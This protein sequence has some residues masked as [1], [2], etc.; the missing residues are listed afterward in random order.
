MPS[1][2]DVTNRMSK[3]KEARKNALINRSKLPSGDV[4]TWQQYFSEKGKKLISFP[5]SGT[6]GTVGQTVLPHVG[7]HTFAKI[8]VIGCASYFT[9]PV[10]LAGLIASVGTIS[11]FGVEGQL[12]D[13][14][15]AVIEDLLKGIAQSTVEVMHGRVTASRPILT[16]MQTDGLAKDASEVC[17]AVGLLASLIAESEKLNKPA[18]YCDDIAVKARISARIQEELAT[19]K[20]KIGELKTKVNGLETI[21]NGAVTNDANARATQVATEALRVVA[22]DGAWHYEDKTYSTLQ[23]FN[24]TYRLN[25]CSL[26]HCFGPGVGSTD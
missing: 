12:V 14:G 10:W 6:I 3:N 13:Y 24:P 22:K 11:I 18:V 9:A 1:Q 8:A 7:L 15:S 26:D 17:A 20:S 2:S 4:R 25:H 23:G 19:V 5:G 21:V 16:N